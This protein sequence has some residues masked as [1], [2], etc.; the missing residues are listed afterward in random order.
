MDFPTLG[1]PTNPTSAMTLSSTR[2]FLS[3]PGSPFSAIL[4]AGFLEVA[5]RKFP[6]PPTPPLAIIAC[7]PCAVKSASM[8]PVS[9]SYTVVPGGT[10][11]IKGSAFLPC[12]LLLIPFSPRSALKCRLYLK[13]INVF[14]PSST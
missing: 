9:S 13:S 4:G 8:F 6:L 2:I 14:N 5:K 10:G 1:K 3:S 7:C 11:T 12:L